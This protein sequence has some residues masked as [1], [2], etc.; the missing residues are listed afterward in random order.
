MPDH[1]KL[2]FEQV[3]LIVE[4]ERSTLKSSY[5]GGY[6]IMNDECACVNAVDDSALPRGNCDWPHAYEDGVEAHKEYGAKSCS[7]SQQ[8][9]ECWLNEEVGEMD[10]TF[11]EIIEGAQ[12]R[13]SGDGVAALLVL[14]FLGSWMEQEKIGQVELHERATVAAGEGD[15]FE[16]ESRWAGED[17]RIQ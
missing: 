2:D 13:F 4:F 16:M 7:R 9:W 14:V 12:R 10:W 15:V 17:W 8:K 3:S 1:Q 11:A 5:I 6:M